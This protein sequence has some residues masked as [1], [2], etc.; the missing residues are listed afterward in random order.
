MNG[1]VLVGTCN[2]GLVDE[3]HVAPDSGYPHDLT[4]LFGL[5]V[6]EFDPLPA[7]TENHLAVRHGFIA[8]HLHTARVWCDI[9]K[10]TTCQV[11][12]TFSK[13]FYAGSAALTT[14]AYGNGHAI[15]VATLS[16]QGFYNDLVAYL[17]QNFAIHP[18]LKV[19][20][21]VEV[22]VREKDGMRIYFLLNHQNSPI[23]LNFYKPVHDFLTNKTITGHFDLPPRGVLVLDEAVAQQ[24]R[25]PG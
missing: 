21:N 17:R 23:R 1:G 20:D 8:T 18:A 3:H 2:T 9:I 13:D 6:M 22:S 24:P 25:L 14:N 16:T 7:G 4:D 11:L 19:A 10:P 15:Y 12:A 5:E